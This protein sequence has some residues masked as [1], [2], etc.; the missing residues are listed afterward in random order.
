MINV[1]IL[2]HALSD[3]TCQEFEQHNNMINTM[4]GI[5][6]SLNLN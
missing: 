3:G 2:N 4:N 6:A 5:D 1:Q